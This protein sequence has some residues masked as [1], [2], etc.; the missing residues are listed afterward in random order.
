MPPR[1]KDPKEIKAEIRALKKQVAALGKEVKALFR[2]A[3][4]AEKDLAKRTALIEKL[5]AKLVQ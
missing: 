1:K 2:T 3:T 4:S 5:E